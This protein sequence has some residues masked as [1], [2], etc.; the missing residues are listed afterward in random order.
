MSGLSEV[1]ATSPEEVL[2]LLAKGNENRSTE[3]T[4]ANQVLTETRRLWQSTVYL[5]PLCLSQLFFFQC[6]EGGSISSLTSH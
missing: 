5:P 4:A 1:P 2:A 3:A 6:Y